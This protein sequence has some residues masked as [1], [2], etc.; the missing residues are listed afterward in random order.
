MYFVAIIEF[1]TPPALPATRLHNCVSYLLCM[2]QLNYFKS[3]HFVSVVEMVDSQRQQA[4]ERAL[5]M[6]AMLV[7]TKKELAEAKK[8][9]RTL[10]ESH[11]FPIQSPWSPSS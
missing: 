3:I 11:L 2:Q 4:E 6:K 1:H 5:K 8:Q 7:K 10:P 9:V